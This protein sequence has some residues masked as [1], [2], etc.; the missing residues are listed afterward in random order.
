MSAYDAIILDAD[1]TLLN[2]QSE[3]RPAV[4]AALHRAM[5][6]GVLV[7]LA[8]GRSAHTGREVARR[9]GSPLPAIVFNGAGLYCTERDRMI[10]FRA[11]DRAL[12]ASVIALSRREGFFWYAS[13]AEGMAMSPPIT[14]EDRELTRRLDGR[15]LHEDDELPPIDV[16]RMTVLSERHPDSASL[17]EPF[18]EIVDVATTQTRHYPLS[19]VPAFRKSRRVVVDFEPHGGGKAEAIRF[20]EREHGLEASRIVAVGDAGNDLPMLRE[21]GLSVAMENATEEVKAACHRTI[22]HHNSLTLVDLVE[23]LFF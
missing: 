3:I 23:E 22:G 9:L 16:V 8:T 20:L 21:A 14:S 13:H 12:V 2:D 5:D 6:V 10:D 18:R 17:F 1:G 7:M 19:E 11:L 15:V 4:R